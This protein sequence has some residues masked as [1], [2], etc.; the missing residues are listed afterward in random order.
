M[1]NGFVGVLGGGG[2]LAHCIRNGEVPGRQNCSDGRGGA[3]V[4]TKYRFFTR[5]LCTFTGIHHT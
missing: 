5:V 3:L 2:P 4:S 1:A